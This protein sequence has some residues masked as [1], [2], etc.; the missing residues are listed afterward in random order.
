MKVA[1]ITDTHWSIRNDSKAFADYFSRFYQNVFFPYLKEH[2]IKTLIHL[3]DIFDKRK[4][5]TFFAANRM[6]EDLIIPMNELGIEGHFII[7]NHDVPYRNINKYN[8]MESLFHNT[9]YNL[10]YYSDPTEIEIDGTTIL[11]IPWINTENYDTTMD[12]VE[13]TKAQIMFGHLELQGFQMYLGTVN[14]EGLN[15]DVFKKFDIIGTG[16]FHHKSTE[17]NVN[18]LGAP[19]EMTWGDFNDPRG[20]HIFDTDTRELTFIQNPYRMFHKIYYSDENKNLDEILDV[21]LDHIKDCVV[22][23]IIINKT[24][25]MFFDQYMDRIEKIGV[26]EL[27]VV[28]DHRNLDVTDDSDLINEVEDTITIMNNYVAKMEVS[29]KDKTALDTLFRQ[30]HEEV[31]NLESE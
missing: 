4:S 30:L 28:E 13:T 25:P 20:F 9:N 1:L 18:Y 21:S 27:Q 17:K 19:Y 26:A 8:S 16:H 10:K 11:L 12:L 5:V 14:T 24:N 6:K 3:G 15:A 29:E 23:V 31:Y 2:N 7:G 22:K